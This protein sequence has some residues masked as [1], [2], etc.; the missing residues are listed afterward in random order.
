V[1]RTCTAC[2]ESDVFLA[3]NP[4]THL[5]GFLTTVLAVCIGATCVIVSPALTY[6]QFY[7]ICNKFQV[8]VATL[9]PKKNLTASVTTGTTT[10]DRGGRFTWAA[11]TRT[12]ADAVWGISEG[13]TGLR[14]VNLFSPRSMTAPYSHRKSAPRMTSLEQSCRTT[15]FTGHVSPWISTRA[16]LDPVTKVRLGPFNQGE[17]VFRSPTTMRG[18]YKQPK[19]TAEFLEPSG[20]CHSGDIGF[21]DNSG[22]IHFVRRLK[23]VIK[24]MDN[25]VAPAELEDI[26]LRC[27]EGIADVAVVGLP[28]PEYGEA[29][30]AFI[31]PKDEPGTHADISA[32]EVKRLIAET[33]SKYKQLFG[34]VYFVHSLP[35]M[36]S[37]KVIKSALIE[38]ATH[39]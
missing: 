14:S 9:A 26:L 18:Y 23:D 13:G 7:D 17:L 22:R 3:W 2:D 11:A 28:H 1:N 8:G 5:S 31:L 21:Y 39:Q 24:C 29:A 36:K 4:I 33:C 10:L 38:A 25:Q 32:R 30:A 27:H 6:N 12:A 19:A 20:W 37:G 15:N 16:F 35:R 34:G